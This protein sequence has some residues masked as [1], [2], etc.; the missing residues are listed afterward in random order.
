MQ[1]F[2]PQFMD[3]DCL[4]VDIYTPRVPSEEPQG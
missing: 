2:G 4:Y 3:E 1:P